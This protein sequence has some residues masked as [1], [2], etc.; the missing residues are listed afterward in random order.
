MEDIIRESAWDTYQGWLSTFGPSHPET[1]K[2]K[3]VYEAICVEQ[4]L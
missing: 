4:G 1:V 2:A 3:Q